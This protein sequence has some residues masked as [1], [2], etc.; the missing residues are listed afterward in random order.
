MT[1]RILAAALAFC[2][3]GSFHTGAT[4]GQATTPADQRATRKADGRTEIDQNSD[5]S[6][7]ERAREGIPTKTDRP[8]GSPNAGVGGGRMQ[9]SRRQA[10]YTQHDLATLMTICNESEVA[11]SRIGAQ[12]ARNADVKKFA[13]EMVK[14]HSDMIA[15]IQQADAAGI[16]AA[17]GNSAPQNR[18]AQKVQTAGAN[19]RDPNQAQ[20]NQTQA[21]QTGANQQ[22]NQREPNQGNASGDVVGR[23]SAS[24]DASES[25]F[26]GL[27]REIAEQCRQSMEQELNSK[28]GAEFDK[29]FMGAQIG[30]H[31]EAIDS[32][33]VFQRHTS[34]Q[35]RQTIDEG[36]ASAQSH[37]EHA[38]KIMKDLE[39]A[40]K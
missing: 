40:A 29:C 14:V 28:D 37:L 16:A 30:A 7:G 18:E 8:V 5:K 26:V 32:M 10:G 22:A 25:G 36:I 12:K 24:V 23:R 17:E 38:K 1:K 34:G 6:A 19:Q 15:K 11:L 2:A 9:M 4:F 39:S 35:L 31:M 20:P 21:N 33:K 27:K 3:L 13:E